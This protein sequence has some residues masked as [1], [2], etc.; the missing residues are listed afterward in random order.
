[1]RNPLKHQAPQGRP[2][3]AGLLLSA[4]CCIP[5]AGCLIPQDEDVIPQLPPKRNGP[6]QIRAQI[7]AQPRITFRNTTLCPTQ[8]LPFSLTVADE[9][10]GDVVHSIWF[11]GGA[12]DQRLFE[13]TPIQSGSSTSRTVTAPGSLGFKSALA[14]LV[15]GTEILTVY[16]ADT[17][18]EEVVGGTVALVPRPT[19]RLPDGTEA[20]DKGSMDT[21]TWTLDVKACE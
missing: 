19:T 3:M 1:M 5:L 11:I 20:I 9:D 6:I 17:D 7:P 10:V 4:L 21:F 13:P 14:N 8:N 2:A 12:S 16:V 15:I 18:F